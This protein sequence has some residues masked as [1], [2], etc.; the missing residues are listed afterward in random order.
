MQCITNFIITPDTRTSLLWMLY[1][2]DDDLPLP[3]IS[4]SRHR[5]APSRKSCHPHEKW[6]GS[7][8]ATD[9]T[10]WQSQR[11]TPPHPPQKIPTPKPQSV[12]SGV[13]P[14]SK[15]CV[16]GPTERRR[17]PPAPRVMRASAL[18][19]A[20]FPVH[21]RS[22]WFSELGTASSYT[23]VTQRRITRQIAPRAAR[24]QDNRDI[25][26]YPCSIHEIK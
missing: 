9:T 3:L 6:W 12:C 13:H 8:K 16:P 5:V 4:W 19:Y 14:N 26:L 24:L 15:L 7:T 18:H 2:L 11:D 17:L 20:N 1:F 22:P 10:R 21:A 23:P 25:G